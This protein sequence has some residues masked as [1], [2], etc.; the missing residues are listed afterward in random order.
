MITLWQRTFDGFFS[1]K[2]T[3]L[4]VDKFYTVVKIV[5]EL[6]FRTVVLRRRKITLV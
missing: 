5:F 4:E 2:I 3:L 1:D 6:T